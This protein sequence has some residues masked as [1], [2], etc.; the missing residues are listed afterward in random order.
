MDWIIFFL[1]YRYQSRESV[2]NDKHLRS[3]FFKTST[4]VQ[5]AVKF[6]ELLVAALH[7]LVWQVHRSTMKLSILDL[8]HPF[9]TG[10]AAQVLS[11]TVRDL[12]EER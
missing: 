12:N 11:V 5:K 6:C 8:L 9:F 1:N 2:Q 3:S 4:N 10:Q 7:R